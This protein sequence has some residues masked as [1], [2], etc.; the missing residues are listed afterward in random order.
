MFA[1]NNH[2]SVFEMLEM[3][4]KFHTMMKN[5]SNFYDVRDSSEI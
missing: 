2:I 4:S 5:K 3:I 1:D